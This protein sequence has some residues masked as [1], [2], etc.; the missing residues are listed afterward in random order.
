MPT[1]RLSS[2]A[3]S[4]SSPAFFSLPRFFFT[5]FSSISCPRKRISSTRRGAS[6]DLASRIL[7]IGFGFGGGGGGGGARF[8]LGSGSASFA[9]GRETL[10][11]LRFR[12]ST[13]TSS[14][15]PQSF[16]PRLRR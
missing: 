8:R 2:V 14:D 3:T 4:G 12:G 6:D 5:A 16:A 15:A 1:T 13:A 10:V 11:G 9:A 7:G